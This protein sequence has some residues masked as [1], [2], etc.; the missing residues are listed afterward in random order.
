[1]C[2][3]PARLISDIFVFTGDIGGQVQERRR[4]GRISRTQDPEGRQRW[5]YRG[6]GEI[7]GRKGKELRHSGGRCGEM[8]TT[9]TT[10]TAAS[11]R[12]IMNEDPPVSMQDKSAMEK[13]RLGRKV[14]KE[15]AEKSA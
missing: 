11:R 5:G 6:R 9:E 2:L 13:Y 8:E 3:I 7:Q 4:E 14:T 1:M 10:A 12:R 15:S